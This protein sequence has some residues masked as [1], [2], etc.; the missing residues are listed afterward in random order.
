MYEIVWIY[1]LYDKLWLNSLASRSIHITAVIKLSHQFDIHTWVNLLRYVQ[2]V[3]VWRQN[4]EFFYWSFNAILTFSINNY[5]T[6][7]NKNATGQAPR[8]FGSLWAG[9][10]FFRMSHTDVLRKRAFLHVL[11]LFWTLWTPRIVPSK[12]WDTPTFQMTILK[13]PQ[14]VTH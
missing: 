13:H 2:C 9:S 12:F 14:N 7:I 5:M 8:Y 6:P 4:T 11:S 10:Q 1:E 3:S